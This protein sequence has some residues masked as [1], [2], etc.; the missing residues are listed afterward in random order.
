MPTVC[1][2]IT[3]LL[4][5]WILPTY[6]NAKNMYDIVGLYGSCETVSMHSFV[7]VPFTVLLLILPVKRGDTG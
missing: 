1:I 2:L 3:S 4:P 6:Q 7:H 5:A